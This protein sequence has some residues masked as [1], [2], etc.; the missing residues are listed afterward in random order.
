[1]S[2]S[3]V[4]QNT[5]HSR[6]EL[7]VEGSIA[8]AYYRSAGDVVTFTHTEVPR[9]FRGRGI[10]SRLVEGAL[11]TVRA[12]GLRVVPQCSFVARYIAE[13]PQFHDLLK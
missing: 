8:V 7:E 11:E 2:P 4:R 10:A 6:F 3:S 5:A 1:M 9:Q 13:H 12:Q